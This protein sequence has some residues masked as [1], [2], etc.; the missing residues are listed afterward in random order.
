MGLG[1]LIRLYSDKLDPFYLRF[2]SYHKE[3]LVLGSSRAAQ[4]IEPSCFN[5]ALYNFSFTI[6]LSPFDSTYLKLIQKYHPIS[7]YDSSRLH[8]ITVDPWT[9]YTYKNQMEET[10]NPSFEKLLKAPVQN[11]NLHYIYHFVPVLKSLRTILSSDNHVNA[12]GRFV[13]PMDSASLI[14][15]DKNIQLKIDFYKKKPE[16]T[17]GYLSEKRLDVLKAMIEYLSEDGRVVLVRL[18]VHDLMF[19]IEQNMAPDFDELMASTGKTLQVQYINLMPQRN[20]YLYTDGN[21]IW[22]GHVKRL[23]EAIKKRIN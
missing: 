12:G 21:H 22:N 18:P 7:H 20:N 10:I 1:I 16:Y 19:A 5:H 6:K 17:E 2:T 14:Q 4:A 9:L 11:P 15:N 23:S 3:G 13:V 8:I